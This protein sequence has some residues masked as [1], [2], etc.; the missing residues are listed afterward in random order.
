MRPLRLSHPLTLMSLLLF[1]MLSASCSLHAASNQPA[2][3]SNT[4]NTTMSA[5]DLKPYP[6]AVAGQQRQVISLPAAANEADLK[7]ELQIGKMLEID[8]NHHAFGGQLEQRTAKGWGY[9]YYVLEKVG[10]P[11]STL[12]GCPENSKRNEWVA[13]QLGEAGFVRYNSKLPVVVYIPDG[14]ELRYRLWRGDAQWHTGSV[15]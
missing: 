15:R 10:G 7:V 4:V 11:M 1:A 9:N 8:C 6:A 5:P 3:S 2:S 14:F 12:M 13:V